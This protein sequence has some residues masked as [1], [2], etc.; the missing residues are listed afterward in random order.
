MFQQYSE[1][2]L[3]S[4]R[5]GEGS[6]S[7]IELVAATNHLRRAIILNFGSTSVFYAFKPI[8]IWLKD[9]Q[10]GVIF[11]FLNGLHFDT[12]AKE[13]D[14]Q[15]HS[16]DIVPY[17]E[18]HYLPFKLNNPDNS[19]YVHN[20]KS[21]KRESNITGINRPAFPNKLTKRHR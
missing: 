3:F 4:H 15:I 6:L 18:Q 17:L 11:S 14:A 19:L 21:N 13:S 12:S 8:K 20:N 10:K 9:H 2:G 7:F 16:K 1:D 5:W